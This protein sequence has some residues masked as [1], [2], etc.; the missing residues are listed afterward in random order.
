MKIAVAMS[1]G[2]D[3][4]TAMAIADS[5]GYQLHALSFNYNQRHAIEI[6][7]AKKVARFYS[8]ASHLI[9]DFNLRAIGGSALTGDKEVPKARSAEAIARGIPDTYVP[10]RNTIFLSFALALAEKV[11]ERFPMRSGKGARGFPLDLRGPSSDDPKLNA[12]QFASRD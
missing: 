5:E 4:S 9:I 10:A 7:A 3:S 1:G 8:A 12:R 11:G 2:V 6:E